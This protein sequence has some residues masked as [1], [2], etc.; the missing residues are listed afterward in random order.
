MTALALATLASLA[1]AQEAPPIVNGQRTSDFAQVGALLAYDGQS[2]G[3]FCSGTLI[4]RKWVVTAA[5]CLA[6]DGGVAYYERYGYDVYFL[7]GD[8]AYSQT[9]IDELVLVTDYMQHPD[10]NSQR[11]SHDIG[12]LE[13]ET[14]VDL[15][16]IPLNTHAPSNGWIGRDLDYVGWG[17]TTDNG[18]DSGIKRTA[19]IGYYDADEQF[20][21][22]YDDTFNLCSGDSGGASLY[23]GDDGGYEIVG[24]NSFVYP[25]QSQSTSCVG[26]GSGATRIDTHVEWIGEHVPLE[27]NE[28]TNND[29]ED[30]GITFNDD[31]GDTPSRP[32]DDGNDGGIK[33]GCSSTSGGAGGLALALLGLLALGRRRR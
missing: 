32:L 4:H 24:V 16:P 11:L 33:G 13:L 28:P 27:E 5:H 29:P 22:G 21:Y 15:E 2:G 25:V 10:Y 30:T 17:V 7:I 31:T 12:L 9:G 20:I 1:L 8:N 14:E 23:E 3:V 26:G 6:A 19:R 18:N